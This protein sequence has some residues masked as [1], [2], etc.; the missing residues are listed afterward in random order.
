MKDKVAIA[1]VMRKH[2]L[3]GDQVQIVYH[4]FGAFLWYAVR[5]HSEELLSYACSLNVNGYIKPNG[6]TNNLHR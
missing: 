2:G 6:R 5:I 1:I 4:D 3:L